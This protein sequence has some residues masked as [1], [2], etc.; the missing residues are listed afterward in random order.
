MTERAEYSEWP[1]E[2]G[3]EGG[4]HDLGR[5]FDRV[6]A[7]SRL[8]SVSSLHLKVNPQ[9]AGSNR[10]LVLA[11]CVATTFVFSASPSGGRP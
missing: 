7:E 9:L 6:A 3:L 1:I 4:Y 2:V 11:S 5:F 10:G 8:I